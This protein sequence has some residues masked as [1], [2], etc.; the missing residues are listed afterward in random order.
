MAITN[1]YDTP[2]ESNIVNT[3]TPIP[4]DMIA[5]A[6]MERQ[7][8]YDQAAL[9]EDQAPELLQGPALDRVRN[10]YTG[11][12]IDVQDK[13][14][15]DRARQ[16]FNARIDNLAK[17]AGTADKGD[18]A[19]QRELRK[20]YRDAAKLKRE[21][22]DPAAANYKA[23]QQLGER[24]AEADV[25]D[26]RFLLG[27]VSRQL[28]QYSKFGEDTGRIGLL[29]ANANIGEYVDRAETLDDRL[30]GINSEILELQ[31]QVAQGLILESDIEGITENKIREAADKFLSTGTLGASYRQEAEERL[32]AGE[33]KASVQ[34]QIATEQELLK[35][36]MVAKYQKTTGSRGIKGDGGAGAIAAPTKYNPLVFGTTVDTSTLNEDYS[37]MIG[38]IDSGVYQFDSSGKLIKN[39]LSEEELDN[40]QTIVDKNRYSRR[41]MPVSVSR[42]PGGEDMLSQILEKYGD[43]QEI[44]AY[45]VD[46]KAK[47]ILNYLKEVSVASN[48]AYEIHPQ[49][50]ESIK[51]NF[52]SNKAVSNI[53]VLGEDGLTTSTRGRNNVVKYLGYTETEFDELVNDKQRQ[54]TLNP[55]TGRFMLQVPYKDEKKGHAYVEVDVDK[56]STSRLQMAAQINNSFYDIEDY[57]DPKTTRVPLAKTEDGD[58]VYAYVIGRNDIRNPNQQ[59]KKI[60]VVS[61][62]TGETDEI[63]LYEFNSIIARE[64][65]AKFAHRDVDYFDFKKRL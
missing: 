65:S 27:E 50:Q 12:S 20:A 41:I 43:R 33:D 63:S 18:S 21:V 13:A 23:Y 59:N 11:K 46:K 40:L 51:S 38:N 52:I 48:S 47:V 3:Y 24:V 15:V 44:R 5:K 64:I 16:E 10:F 36:A 9:L 35:R 8:R 2:A 28:E 32:L 30:S 49:A 25:K 60:M 14:I 22:I 6:G 17:K 31:A 62:Q 45:K 7:R 26:Q 39:D 29:D 56:A 37:Q 53:S 55:S 42:G 57:T 54:F 34:E 1:R 19:Y 4:F 61:P 58:Q